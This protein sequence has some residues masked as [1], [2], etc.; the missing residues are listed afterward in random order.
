MLLLNVETYILYL[1]KRHNFL[2]LLTYNGTKR[3]NFYNHL[4]SFA[5]FYKNNSSN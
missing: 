2:C 1:I 4:F 3:N 5:Y